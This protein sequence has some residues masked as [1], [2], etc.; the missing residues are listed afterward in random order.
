MNIFESIKIA[1][2]SIISNKMRS[3]LTMLGIIIG[4]SSVIAVVAIGQ[5]GQAALNKEMD[6]FGANRFIVFYNQTDTPFS[7]SDIFSVQDINTI[8]SISTL[9]EKL[10]PVS[11]DTC[12][13]RNKGK[14]IKVSITATSADYED[15]ANLNTAYGRF[16]NQDDENAKRQV[17]V[18][19]NQLAKELFGSTKAI[20]KKIM[21]QNRPFKV[22][23]V[24]GKEESMMFGARDENIVYIPITTYHL[25]N[26]NKWIDNLEGKAASQD[27][28]DRAVSQVLSILER[29]HRKKDRYQA[30]NAEKEM[31]AVRNVTGIVAL[32]ISVIAGIS[33][34]VGGI[35]IMNIMLVSVTERTREI[36]IRKALGARESDIMLQFMIE[37][38][39]LSFIGGIIGMLLGFGISFVIAKFVKIPPQISWQMIV[40]AFGFSAGVGV[41][42]GIY[43]AKKAAYQDPIEALRYE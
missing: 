10:A 42:F 41:F 43:P 14:D 30:F 27:E 8:K 5:G 7:D 6:S 18:I 29:R 32:V 1:I 12:K 36:G 22:I 13:V 9:V 16:F 3:L 34:L 33:L 4:V 19:N 28:V 20:G 21:L 39:V 24:L 37:S 26:S 31:N 40:L 23:G 25:L 2:D 11:Y 38:L 35:G 17:S 15:I